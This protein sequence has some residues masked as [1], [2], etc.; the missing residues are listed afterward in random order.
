[1]NRIFKKYLLFPYLLPVFFVLHI[2]TDNYDFIPAQA[3]L[4]L[5]LKHLAA[6]ILLVLTFWILYRNFTKASL[7]TFFLI[8]LNFIFGYLHD[9]SKQLFGNV[10]ITRYSFIIPVICLFVIICIVCI[11]K[12]KSQ[13][14]KTIQ[15]L[16][17]LLLL[18]IIIDIGNLLIKFSKKD[19]KETSLLIKTTLCDTCSKPDIYLIIADEYAGQTELKDIFGFDNS[20]FLNK[21]KE[22]GY[23]VLANTS[24]NYNF[25]HYSMASML[26][27][28]YLKNISGEHSSSHD[29]SISFKAMKESSVIN[30]LDKQGYTFYNYSIFNFDKQ[31]SPAVS[32]FIPEQT[33]PVTANTFIGR[34]QKDLGYHLVTTLKLK[35][36]IKNLYYTDLYNND[37]IYELT[38]KI[39][40]E[41]SNNPKFV[42]SHLV[43]P[44]YRYYYDSSG[45]PAPFEKVIDDNY[46]A[47]KNAYL[48]YLKYSNEKLMS[49]IDH[50]KNTSP[51]PPVILLMSDHG[52]HQFLSEEDIKN[53]DKKYYFKNLNTV[54][55]PNQ[56]YSGFYDSMTN[57][58]Q[59]RVVLNSL[60]A[61][62]IPLLKDST[63]FLAQ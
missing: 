63:I 56:N 6:T 35:G 11:K 25:T 44:H 52:Y 16:N 39:S 23:H 15:Y 45:N 2:F 48:E 18:L 57:V 41:K 17:W 28:N 46:C 38:K 59:F 50:I 20:T 27:M 1:M 22:R 60:F 24:G 37:K 4:I 40:G 62:K 32:T 49:L 61:Q 12:S 8:G 53:V 26:D 58:N 29:L 31:P 47:D 5:T 3:A 33:A 43:M 9:F 34:V 42:Y 55:F 7:T 21:L 36:A 30:F 13:F 54:Y 51:K 10:L 19:K 14:A